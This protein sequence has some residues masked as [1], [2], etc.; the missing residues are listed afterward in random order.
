MGSQPT[1]HDPL[2]NSVSLITMATFSQI[3]PSASMSELSSK[4]VCGIENYLQKSPSHKRLTCSGPN[5]NSPAHFLE[6]FFTHLIFRPTVAMTC[7]TSPLRNSLAF[8]LNRSESVI[9]L[10]LLPQSK[11]LA[12]PSD[13]LF[14]LKQVF[15]M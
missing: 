13:F 6:L 11:Q 4:T 5:N 2:L 12:L 10:P 8:Q 14:Q 15:P 7:L 9:I 1:E 3:I